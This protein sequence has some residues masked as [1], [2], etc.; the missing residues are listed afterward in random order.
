M[1]WT[2][3]LFAY[4]GAMSNSDS[5]A[6]TTVSGF[7]TQVECQAAGEQSKKM[8]VGST[9]VIKSYCVEVQK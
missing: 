9:K 1:N 6:L 5:M 3:I 2:L 8:A 7:R 4:A